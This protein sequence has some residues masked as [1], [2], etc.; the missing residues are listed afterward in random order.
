MVEEAM[1]AI[2]ADENVRETL[3]QLNEDANLN[4]AEQIEQ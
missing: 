2:M 3:D 4:L 1:V